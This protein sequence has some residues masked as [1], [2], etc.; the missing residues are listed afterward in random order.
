MVQR[1]DYIVVEM[2]SR[3]MHTLPVIIHGRPEANSTIL[4]S[5]S[6]QHRHNSTSVR[7]T[8]NEIDVSL[9]KSE[10][11]S[12]LLVLLL[13]FI[14]FYLLFIVC[15]NK[16]PF[17]IWIRNPA[18]KTASVFWVRV[19]D[20]MSWRYMHKT[21]HTKKADTKWQAPLGVPGGVRDGGTT[22]WCYGS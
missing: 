8:Q 21:Q 14:L 5:W 9:W 6:H 12:F 10:N 2:S 11:T 17:F 16:K 4:S 18:G 15:Y 3:R 19:R 13:C 20:T 7:Q 22:A 1:S